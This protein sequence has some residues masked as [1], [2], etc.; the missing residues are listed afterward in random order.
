M[1]R[2]T[3]ALLLSLPFLLCFIAMLFGLIVVVPIWM[4]FQG[5][6]WPATGYIIFEIMM[7]GWALS[8]E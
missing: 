3:P 6:I 5:Q 2:E 8:Y 1:K 7:F 4:L